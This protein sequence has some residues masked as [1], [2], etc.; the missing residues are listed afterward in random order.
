[1]KVV[2]VRTWIVSVIINIVNVTNC[3][4][5]HSKPGRFRPVFEWSLVF[6]WHSTTGLH[7]T[8]R[9]PDMSGYRFPTVFANQICFHSPVFGSW[10]YSWIWLWLF[11]CLRIGWIP[12]WRIFLFR[13]FPR[14]WDAR[15]C[16]DQKIRFWKSNIDEIFGVTQTRC[17]SVKKKRFR[18]VFNVN[19]VSERIESYAK[20]GRD[21]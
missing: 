7:S 17:T 10:L 18:F 8:I 14:K 6:E 13:Q 9:K 16:S 19:L 1:M 5:N 12:I 4:S 3:G 11:T 2:I 21:Y 15:I 20:S